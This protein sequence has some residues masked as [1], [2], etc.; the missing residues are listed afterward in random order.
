[1]TTIF[2]FLSD[3]YHSEIVWQWK[4]T[5]FFG[6][7]FMLITCG[8]LALKKL[9]GNVRFPYLW[10]LIVSQVYLSV[11][12]FGWWPM[13]GAGLFWKKSTGDWFVLREK[14]CW[15]LAHKL[16]EQVVCVWKFH[17]TI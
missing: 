1:L 12:S 17:L 11:C 13:A 2:S 10:L 3:L 8:C 6:W 15:L 5:F 4:T 16:S 14:Y 7:L 9:C